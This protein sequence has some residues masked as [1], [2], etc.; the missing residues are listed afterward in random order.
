MTLPQRIFFPL[1]ALFILAGCARPDTTLNINPTMN[2]PQQDPSL[3]GATISLTSAD[4]RQDSALAKVNRDGQLLTLTPSRDVRFLLQEALEKQ[5]RARGYMVGPEGSVNVQ[6][7]INNLY[8]DVQEGD[9]RYNI[10]TKVN[11]SIIS[12]AKNGQQQTKN[13]RTTHN[14]KGAF[15]AS[16]KNIEDVINA[17]LTDTINEMAQDTSISD[18]IRQN[19]RN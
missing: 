12:Q 15:T 19:A 7:I 18:F 1:M 13:F 2:L 9:L 11:I 10:V 6:I 17:A 8:A 4:Q 5:L 3:M 16:N 14:T